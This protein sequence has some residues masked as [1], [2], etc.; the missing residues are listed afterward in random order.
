MVES[1]ISTGLD[2]CFA[3]AGE[4]LGQGNGTAI[5]GPRC[6]VHADIELAVRKNG[7][8]QQNFKIFIAAIVFDRNSQICF[9]K[10][11]LTGSVIQNNLAR[12]CARPAA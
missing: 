6:P 10:F 3:Q 5:V 2:E 11:M 8:F 9:H 7:T 4:Q 12:A 1:S